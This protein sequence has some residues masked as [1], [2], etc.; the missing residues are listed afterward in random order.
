MINEKFEAEKAFESVSQM[1][2]QTSKNMET[3]SSAFFNFSSYFFGLDKIDIPKAEHDCLGVPGTLWD[4]FDAF[5][6][7]MDEFKDSVSILSKSLYNYDYVNF[8]EICENRLFQKSSI[9]KTLKTLE[10]GRNEKIILCEQYKK[11]VDELIETIDNKKN[12]CSKKEMNML[13]QD[14]MNY[15]YKF[16]S[17]REKIR[18]LND[19]INS[20]LENYTILLSNIE[21]NSNVQFVGNFLSRIS[22]RMLELSQN[23]GNNYTKVTN[24]VDLINFDTDFKQFTITNNFKFIDLPP[25]PVER[26]KFSSRFTAP[27]K[28]IIPRFLLKYF[29][30][31]MAKAKYDFESKSQDELKLTKNQRI[32]LLQKPLDGWVLAMQV[33][34]SISGFVPETYIE[35]IGKGLAVLKKDLNIPNFNGYSKTL[36]AVLSIDNKTVKC[37]DVDGNVANI[38]NDDLILLE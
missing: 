17:E 16:I 28:Q 34:Y 37:E 11:H 38:D 18:E 8:L 4:G 14:L 25:P 21:M 36:L 15:N 20:I 33:A 29:P 5:V 22:N 23:L 19:S 31:C 30:L 32:F 27:D 26:F 24:V 12:K 2:L 10:T 1:Y 9:D 35:V 3:F 13:C 7:S 6:N